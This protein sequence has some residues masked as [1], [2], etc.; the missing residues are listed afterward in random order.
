MR[1]VVSAT[2]EKAAR[3]AARHIA[4]RLGLAITGRGVATL[5]L[6]GGTSAPLLLAEL[7]RQSLDWP[8][9]HVF[10]VDERV[11]PAGDPARN[12]TATQAALVGPG[13]LARERL[14]AMPVETGDANGYA[15]ELVARAGSPPVL[16]VVQLGL[17]VDGHTASLFPEDPA[18]TAD[19]PVACTGEHAGHR[20]MTL[21]LPVINAARRIVWFAHGAEKMP[22]LARLATRGWQAPAGRVARRHA[23]VYT[24]SAAL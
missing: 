22:A 23:V 24:D 19:A 1:F 16:D 21:T 11:V 20:R 7:A 12:L 5:A 6:S 18:L 8:R 17:G 9:L 10:Q 2:P 14:H 13:R 3:A 15:L 4:R